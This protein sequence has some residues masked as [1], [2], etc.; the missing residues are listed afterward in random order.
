MSK[1]Q[2]KCYEKH[3]TCVF[4]SPSHRQCSRCVKNN[5]LCF[6]KNSGESNC[7]QFHFYSTQLNHFFLPFFVKN[8]IVVMI[9]C[10][11]MMALSFK[12]RGLYFP[13]LLACPQISTVIVITATPC[14]AWHPGPDATL[15]IIWRRQRTWTAVYKLNKTT[16][17]SCSFKDVLWLLM[18][19]LSLI[20]TFDTA[21]LSWA[22]G[23]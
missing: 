15:L 1:Y 14:H 20:W 9:C 19:L 16:I 2:K 6:F 13:L 21:V 10:L 5:L 17:S 18:R 8:T 11:N 22:W 23:L 12:M 7:F 4:E 3:Q